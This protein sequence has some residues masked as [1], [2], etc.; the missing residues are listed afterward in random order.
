VQVKHRMEPMTRLIKCLGSEL[1][2][3]GVTWMREKSQFVM[4]LARLGK[5]WSQTV[6]YTGCGNGKSFLVELVAV[7]AAV[8][9]DKES[10]DHF[11][12]FQR[13]LIS[14]AAMEKLRIIFPAVYSV[15]D[16]PPSLMKQTP[17]LLNPVN[18][19]QN[20][21]ECVDSDF[22][23]IITSAAEATLSKLNS[24][25]DNLVDLF[26]PQNYNN[27]LSM[28]SLKNHCWFIADGIIT[29]NLMPS[30]SFNCDWIKPV[31]NRSKEKISKDIY[32]ETRYLIERVF[33]LVA[34]VVLTSEM[35]LSE[36]SLL[37]IINNLQS[38]YSELG[39]SEVD[40]QYLH[41]REGETLPRDVVFTIPCSGRT[42]SLQL[43]LDVFLPYIVD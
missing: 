43:G 22:V 8:Q 34:A 2:G 21:F 35:S 40:L 38:L 28:I 18:P 25:C 15:N 37:T 16:I 19:F 36:F 24:G 14:M 3:D 12:A 23:S 27:L 20:M 30:V 33:R 31:L 17:L 7:S 5:F 29:T 32:K 26:Y 42:R 41:V 13:F 9:E 10:P 1:T 6:L 39:H 4:D 11:R